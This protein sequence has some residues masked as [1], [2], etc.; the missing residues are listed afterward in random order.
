MSQALRYIQAGFGVLAILFAYD[1]AMTIMGGNL[2]AGLTPGW[3]GFATAHPTL[4]AFIL[5]IGAAV[6]GGPFIAAVENF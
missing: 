6:I 1:T 5:V 3:V 2:E 4:F